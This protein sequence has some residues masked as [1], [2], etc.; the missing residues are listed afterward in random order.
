MIM[1]TFLRISA[2]LLLLSSCSWMRR[3]ADIPQVDT[4]LVTSPVI[5]S[6]MREVRYPNDDHSV[7]HI[8][9]YPGGPGEADIPPAVHLRWEADSTAAGP[10]TIRVEEGEW[11][12]EYDVPE[13]SSGIDIY[14]MVPG[15][16]Y[17]WQVL[18]SE[19][20]TV[21]MGR[22]YAAGSLHQVFFQPGVRNARDLGGWKTTDGRTVAFRKLYRGARIVGDDSESVY[23]NAQGKADFAAAGIGAELDLRDT[24]H[25]SSFSPLGS[26][27]TYCAP[28]ISLGGSVMLGKHKAG[29]ARAFRFIVKSLRE[30]RGVYFHCSAGRDRTGTMSALLLG[31][32]G[33]GEGDIGKDYEITYFAP[34]GYSMFGKSFHTRVDGI[35][36]TCHY[37]KKNYGPC[38]SFKQCCEN[39]LLSAGVPQ[40]DIVDFRA[41][42]LE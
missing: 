35:Y 27:F 18:D 1:K 5:D 36:N 4:F 13:D 41:M 25:I 24:S 3:Q 34:K 2:L 14:N 40:E 26:A 28:G 22:F 29:V 15:R 38:D 10:L 37:I 30:G 33:V 32:L 11:S 6:F 39:Y 12:F 16:D 23:F 42:M 20:D 31:V 21:A 7:T 9:K 17:S 8:F 19:K